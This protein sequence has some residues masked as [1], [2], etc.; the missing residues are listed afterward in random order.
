M[1][2]IQADSSVDHFGDLSAGPIAVVRVEL[3]NRDGTSRT[4]SEDGNYPFYVVRETPRDLGLLGRMFG[5]TH[6]S[7]FTGLVTAHARTGHS[8]TGPLPSRLIELLP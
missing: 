6:R 8:L 1:R 4:R 7:G 3:L 2:E 5:R